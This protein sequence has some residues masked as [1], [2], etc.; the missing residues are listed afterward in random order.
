MK[1]IIKELVSPTT[2]FQMEIEF[3]HG[4]GDSYTTRVVDFGPDIV[5]N[6]KLIEFLKRCK[7]AYP[8]GMGGNDGYWDVEGYKEFGGHEDEPFFPGSSPY[9]DGHANL[10]SFEIFWYNEFGSKYAVEITL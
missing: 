1:A 4:D 7:A 9:C 6:W 5:P 8:H 10:Q 2:T 3:M